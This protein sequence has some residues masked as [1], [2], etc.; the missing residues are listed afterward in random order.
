MN[1]PILLLHGPNLDQLGRRP[2][3][4]YGTLT[5][6]ELEKY[7]Q[8]HAAALG[9]QL[10]CFQ[11]NYEGALIER[12]HQSLNDGTAG[13]LVNAGAYT[14][15]S[16]ALADALELASYPVIEVHLSHVH[17]REP[18]RHVSLLSPHVKGCISG[19]GP[20]GYALGLQALSQMVSQ[21]TAA[22]QA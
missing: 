19:L 3:K 5:L 10:H 6:P 12:L 8:E 21:T 2:A 22:P 20:L 18:I 15:T 4:H 1:T 17:A 14:H 13:L 7:C 9:L 11:S 16:L